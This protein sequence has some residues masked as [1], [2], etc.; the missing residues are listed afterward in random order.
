MYVQEACCV[1]A[2]DEVPFGCASS[3][4]FKTGQ[5]TGFPEECALRKCVNFAPD[6]QR[7]LSNLP[8]LAA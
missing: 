2:S 7:I 6:H 1:L 5:P 3:F 8:S 4:I